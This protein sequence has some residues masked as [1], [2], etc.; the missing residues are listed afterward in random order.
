[1]TSLAPLLPILEAAPV[2]DTAGVLS[3]MRGIEQ[4]LAPGEL[5]VDGIAWFNRLYLTVTER[6]I[7]ATQEFQRPDYIATLDVAFANLYFS[8]LKAF[9]QDERS[10]QAPRAWWPVFAGRDRTDV[11]PIQFAIA[12]M[13]AHINRDLP[14]ALAELWRA[15][16]SAL[17]TREQQRQDYQR[18]NVVLA[19]VETDAKAWFLQGPW[20]TAAQA[21][22]GADDAVANFSVTE[23]RE[24]AWAQGEALN[25]LGGPESPLGFAYLEALDGVV[26]LAGRGLLIAAR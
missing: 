22:D 4:Q 3:V 12:G 10:P 20:Q 17:P 5:A 19:G 6:V 13:N 23:A 15:P 7:A 24:A 26:G 16:N 2:R 21:L 11:H 14:V 9:A 8:A 18:V 25:A 1:M